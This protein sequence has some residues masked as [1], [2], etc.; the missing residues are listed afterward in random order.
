MQA[1]CKQSASL[2]SEKVATFVP[3]LG[4]KFFNDK[5]DVQ[6]LEVLTTKIHVTSN[7]RCFVLLKQKVK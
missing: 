1:E 5:P 7:K 6:L 3:S 4:L 2:F